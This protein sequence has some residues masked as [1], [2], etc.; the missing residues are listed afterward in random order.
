M[1][2]RF[3]SLDP[4]RDVIVISSTGLMLNFADGLSLYSLNVEYNRYA[5]KTFE[6]FKETL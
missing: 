2:F 3:L 1:K 6:I 5:F 4:D